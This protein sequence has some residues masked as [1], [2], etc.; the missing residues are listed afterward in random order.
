MQS[1]TDYINMPVNWD[2]TTDVYYPYQANVDGQRWDLQLNDF[3]AEML[4]TLL[5]D[6]IPIMSFDD[7]P[8]AW[9]RPTR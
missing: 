1:I 4:Y 3:P 5:I 7:W 8:S 2:K 6:G 9:K